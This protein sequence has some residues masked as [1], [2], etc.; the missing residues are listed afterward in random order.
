[1]SKYEPL[2][3][4]LRNRR[5]DQW[6]ASFSEIEEVLGFPLPKVARSGRAWWSGDGDKP[7][8]KS[9]SGWQVDADHSEGTVTFRRSAISPGVLEAVGALEP[10]GELPD[11][12]LDVPEPPPPPFALE[13]HPTPAAAPRKGAGLGAML[14][15]TAGVAVGVVV[16][17]VF[18][19]RR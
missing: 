2:A 5:G 3:Q 7:H 13:P 4:H 15:M 10:V 14:A 12:D 17:R 6:K 9:W 18:A 8:A 1:M 11:A 19:R 16:L